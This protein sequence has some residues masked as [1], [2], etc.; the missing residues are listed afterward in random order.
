MVASSFAVFTFICYY[1]IIN[2]EYVIP[3]FPLFPLLEKVEQKFLP[4]IP[5]YPLL[6]KVEQKLYYTFG[7]SGAKFVEKC[8]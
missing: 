2:V 1:W 4:L 6:K 8:G 5:L 3:L 7:K